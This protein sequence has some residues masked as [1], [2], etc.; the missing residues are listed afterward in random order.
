M[1]AR[2]RA[3]ARASSRVATIEAAAVRISVSADALGCVPAGWPQHG[4]QRL[5]NLA[6]GQGG[7]RAGD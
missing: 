2:W 5:D 6:P 7:Q 4:P 3:S 1:M